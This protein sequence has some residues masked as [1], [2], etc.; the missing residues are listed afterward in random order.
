MP[1]AVIFDLFGTLLEIRNRQ[2]PYRLL[3]RLG[4]QQGEGFRRLIEFTSAIT[5][6]SR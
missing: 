6:D 1:A 3:L 5:Q 4:S 2:S